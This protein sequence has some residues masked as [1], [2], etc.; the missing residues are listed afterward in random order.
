MTKWDEA[1]FGPIDD[2]FPAEAAA[3]KA[4]SSTRG[5]EPP[6]PNGPEDYGTSDPPHH[7][8]LP[9]VTPSEAFEGK[10]P[11]FRLR[12]FNNI[13]VG[14]ERVYLVKGIIP[15]TGLVVVWGPPKCGKSFWTF[16]M[17]MHPALAWDYRGR[18]V[19]H[20]AVVYLALEGGKGFEARIEAF[21]QRFLPSKPDEIPFFLVADALNLVK[22]HPELIGCIR[23]QANGNLPVAVVIDTLNR[24]LAGSE[25]EIRHAFGCVVIIVHH[26]GV[27]A[28]RPRGRTS[29]MGAVDAQLAVKRDAVENIVV[30][31]ER[32]KDGPEGETI[33]SKLEAVDVGT[34]LDG[35]PIT[36]CIVAPVDGKAV[37]PEKNRKL[38]DRQRLALDALADCAAD[39]SEPPP[40]IFELPAGLLA[41]KVNDW[42]DKLYSRGVLDREAKSPREDFRRVKNSLQARGLIGE[43]DG[44]VWRAMS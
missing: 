38:S 13:M 28:T 1:T 42:R 22:D 33:V 37:R 21:R 27:D 11:R 4:A 43:R 17:V 35:D 32:M 19:Q 10:S 24:S 41:V 16:D 39:H 18:R 34:D 29:L 5:D 25:S 15:R 31:V 12:A 2:Y 3:E 8:A 20:G 14:S 36:S 30:V 40:A 26:C 9:G 44:L 7:E 6:P 23:L